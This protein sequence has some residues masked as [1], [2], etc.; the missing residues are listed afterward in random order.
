[1]LPD[2]YKS[3]LRSYSRTACAALF[4]GLVT[5][6]LSPTALA[7]Q[8]SAPKSVLV[9]YWYNKDYPWN[10]AFDQSFQ[11]ALESKTSERIEYY[12]EYI[13]SSRF[14]GEKHS[15]LLRDY[16]RQKY[17][18]RSIDLVVATSDVSLDFLLK[19]RHDL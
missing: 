5:C 6:G 2:K 12:S 19:Y 9:L 1:M 4:V 8:S 13:D 18:D 7:E 14:P 15:L 10:V 3:G 11:A 17:A 16:L